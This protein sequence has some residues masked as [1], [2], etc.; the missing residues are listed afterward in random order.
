METVVAFKLR[1]FVIQHVQHQPPKRFYMPGKC[2]RPGQKL[3]AEQIKMFARREADVLDWPP[4]ALEQAFP[5]AECVYRMSVTFDV[6]I[7]SIKF[8][9]RFSQG[10]VSSFMTEANFHRYL[11]LARELA[12]GVG[13]YAGQCNN[14]ASSP[15]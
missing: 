15:T 12:N 14:A 11:N 3:S 6:E 4:E 2:G 7:R 10:G 8:R 13:P 9:R 5:L 1:R